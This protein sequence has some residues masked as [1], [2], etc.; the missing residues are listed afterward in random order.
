[1]TESMLNIN[2]IKDAIERIISSQNNPPKRIFISVEIRDKLLE[3][4]IQDI[5]VKE[6]TLYGIPVVV[7]ANNPLELKYM[8]EY[9]DKIEYVDKDGNGF[10]MQKKKYKPFPFIVEQ[11][12]SGTTFYNSFF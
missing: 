11:F 2:S 10:E 5:S 7:F 8:I 1:M 12:V 3:Y 4:S 6:P 9:D